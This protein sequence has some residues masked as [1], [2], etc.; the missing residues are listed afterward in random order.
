MVDEEMVDEEMVDEEMVDE[1]MVDEE[2]VSGPCSDVAAT[3]DIMQELM[4]QSGQSLRVVTHLLLKT[5]GDVETTRAI[6]L[7]TPGPYVE[8]LWRVAD[9]GVLL[10]G[11]SESRLRL[12][13]KYGAESVTRRLQFL[14]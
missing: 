11:S 8:K 1:Q 14:Q 2:M 5:S 12:Q 4:R 9:D 10:S 3:C 7:G 6:L 13:R